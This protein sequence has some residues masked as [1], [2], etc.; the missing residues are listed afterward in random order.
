MRQNPTNRQR[1]TPILRAVIEVAFIVFL[2]YSNL[3]MGEFT[4]TNG[5][6]K[7]ITFALNDIITG[8]NF[9]IAIITALF[10]WA[11]LEYLRKRL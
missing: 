11:V 4:K 8:M 2:Y 3:L 6:G 1:L 10:G 5:K 7:S 9:S